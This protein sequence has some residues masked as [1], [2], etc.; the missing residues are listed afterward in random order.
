MS[1]LRWIL[2]SLVVALIT[3]SAQAIV[4]IVPS[5][6]DLVN[7]AQAIVIGTAL[8]SHPELTA[9]G[10]IVTV[11]DL[12]LEN[13]LKGAI[14]GD[15]IRI[16]EPGGFMSERAAM[17]PGSP[18]FEQGTR[19]LLLLDKSPDGEWRTSGFQLGQFEFITDLRG[20]QYLS[21]GGEEWIFGLDASDGSEYTDR[22]RSADLF[23]LFVRTTVANP[24]VPAREDYF[25]DRSDVTLAGASTFET[26][27]KLAITPNFTRPDYLMSGFPRWH[28][29]P[30]K[31][32]GYCCAGQYPTMIGSNAINAPSASTSAAQ[33]WN[34]LGSINYTMV[35][36]NT[37]NGGLR[38]TDGAQ[39]VLW[40]D[41]FN[42]LG[43]FPA[44]VVA[45]GGVFTSGT[46]NDLGG[47]I[48]TN[49]LLFGINNH[50]K[51]DSPCIDTGTCT[52]APPTDFEGDPRPSG[53]GCD[54]GADE[55]VP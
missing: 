44:A 52:G 43:S 27:R 4:Y 7:S 51:F 25:V 16:V 18:R 47:N 5:D 37:K 3:A 53:A 42:E 28:T 15:S 17:I 34:G 12:R 54:M 35:G 48:S 49:P 20:M 9:S 32:W 13:V 38:M 36:E 10:S 33:G 2:L 29:G 23:Q 1:K 14:A 46:F 41:P 45:I 55:F 22:F 19:Y 8:T 31:N 26:K 21:R 24:S 40:N 6:R 50:L 39:T 30:T 11:A